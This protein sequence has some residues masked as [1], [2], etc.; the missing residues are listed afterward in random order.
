[1]NDTITP[2]ENSEHE[3]EIRRKTLVALAI[4]LEVDETIA[5]LNADGLLANAETL[6]HLPYKGTV[7]GELP[8]DV[9]Q[10]IETIGSWF[11]TGGKQQEQL[12]FTVGCRALALLQEPLASGHFTTL[13]AWVG[14]WTS[15]T[16]DEVFSR[17]MQK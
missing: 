13:E 11:L 14:Q 10:K 17:L 1:M 7:K 9:Q 3:I 8:P 16:R 2:T 4:S 6:A 15:G 12:K 5:R